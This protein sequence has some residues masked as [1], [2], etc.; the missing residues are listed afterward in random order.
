MAGITFS[1]RLILGVFSRGFTQKAISLKMTPHDYPTV[2][3][4]EYWRRKIRTIFK[5]MD[6]TRDGYLT[7]EDYELSGHRLASY[8]NLDE[9]KAKEVLKLRV[10]G[11]EAIIKDPKNS[12]VYR[13]SEDGYIS[14]LL[15]VINTSFRDA[16]VSL[17]SREFDFYDLDGNGFIS[18]KEHKAL[19]YSLGIPTDY[20]ADAFKALDTDGDGFISRE[21]Y[22][23]GVADFVFSED[24]N[25]P[26]TH[27]FG[28]LIE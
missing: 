5:G 21:E 18:S 3:G 27:F 13:M 7:K 2:K 16:L 15:A 8:M 24:E 22:I 19:F 1:K 9:N 6:A 12:E 26:Y 23:Q 17:A 11:W 20:S 25:S 10:D 28:P 14:D 4:S